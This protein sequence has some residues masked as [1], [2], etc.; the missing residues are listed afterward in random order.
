MSDAEV[1]A[2]APAPSP[3]PPVVKLPPVSEGQNAAGLKTITLT[4]PNGDSTRMYPFGACVTSYICDGVETLKVRP[5]AKMDGSK[6]IS[7]GIPFCFPQF[8]PGA[9]QQHGFARNLVWEVVSTSPVPEPTVLFRLVDSAETRA[10]WDY[11]FEAHYTVTLAKDRLKTSFKVLNTGNDAFSFTA[12]LH[13]YFDISSIANLKIKGNFKGATYLDKMTT[14]PQEVVATSDEIIISK[15]TD[16]V[17]KG[18]SGE[19]KLIDSGKGTTLAVQCKQGWRDTVIWN[20]YGNTDMGFDNFV[21]AEAAL[22][23]F[24]FT[25]KPGVEWTGV[26]DLILSKN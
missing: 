4:H 15:E 14:P 25:L 22:A 20:P 11:A 7:G 21:C 8:G 3:P 12:A 18:V 26:M 19:V 24:P 23:S 17:Y 6:P 1:V 9:I 2:S 10:M 16:C 13:S 5:D